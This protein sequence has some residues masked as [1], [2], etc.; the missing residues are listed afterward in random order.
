MAREKSSL[1]ACRVD[2]L[3]PW[4]VAAPASHCTAQGDFIEVLCDPRL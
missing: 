2:H 3:G 1:L 4:A